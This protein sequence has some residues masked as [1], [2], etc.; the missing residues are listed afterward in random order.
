MFHNVLLSQ[1]S[2]F[3]NSARSSFQPFA[4]RDIQCRLKKV[5]AWPEFQPPPPLAEFRAQREEEAAGSNHCFVTVLF[6][7]VQ[8]YKDHTHQAT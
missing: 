8:N 4:L 7:M 3:C 1:G 6:R 2:S 5:V